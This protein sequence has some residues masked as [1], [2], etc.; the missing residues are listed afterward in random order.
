LDAIAKKIGDIAA[1]AAATGQTPDD[2]SN[3]VTLEVQGVLKD[4]QVECAEYH[5]V[6]D[7]LRSA[8]IEIAAHGEQGHAAFAQLALD[9]KSLASH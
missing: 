5:A 6:I 2:I 1:H 4:H 3:I 7:H 8:L 9:G